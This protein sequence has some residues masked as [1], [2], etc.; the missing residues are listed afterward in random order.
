MTFS[1]EYITLWVF[2]LMGLWNDSSRVWGPPHSTCEV[3]FK[4]EKS[5]RLPWL[6]S[7]VGATKCNAW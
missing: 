5:H 4:D 1:F 6:S 7:I 3:H 2:V